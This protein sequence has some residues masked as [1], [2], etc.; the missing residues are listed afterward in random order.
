M[1]IEMDNRFVLTEG[2]NPNYLCTICKI[3]EMFPIEGADRLVKTV[4]NG[5]DIVIPKTHKEGD[6]VLYFPVETAICEQY[7]S[8]NNLF[9]MSEFERNSNVEEV[10]E[11]LLSLQYIRDELAAWENK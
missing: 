8:A 9:E 2:A 4:I 7:L 6:I 11:K 10:K 1:N 5:Y 3:G